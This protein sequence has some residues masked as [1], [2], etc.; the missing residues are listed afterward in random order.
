MTWNDWMAA[1]KPKVHGTWN[2]H[3]A[4]LDEPLDFFWLASSMVTAMD[5]P[6]QGNYSA[7]NTFLEAFCQYRHS[8]SLPASVLNICPIEGV[9]FVAGNAV[10]RR[11]VKSQGMYCLGE[12]EFLDCVELCISASSPDMNNPLAPSSAPP[13]AW[14][15]TGQIFVGLHSDIHLDDPRNRTNWRHDR[16]M[17]TYHNVRVEETVRELSALKQFLNELADS[18]DVE[19]TLAKPA[20]VEFVSRE[21]GRRIHDLMLKPDEEVDISLSL[22]K[23]GLDSLMAIELRR[24]FRQAFG[25]QIS[26]LEIMRSESLAQLG[27]FVVD[28]LKGKFRSKTGPN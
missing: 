28:K 17:G 4:L 25:L 3:R 10:A 1:T 7:A 11:N 5:Q 19:A 22:A 2:L 8:L 18:D 15:S 24:W 27:Q 21:T 23:I 9:G 20:T 12:R 14:S 16:R 13:T 6:G 26:V